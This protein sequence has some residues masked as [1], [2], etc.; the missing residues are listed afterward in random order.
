MS[1]SQ[2]TSVATILREHVTVEIESLDRLYLNV[3]MPHLQSAAG[4]A[5][6]FRRHR[7]ATFAAA[8]LMDAMTKAFITAIERFAARERVPVIT[9]PKGQRKEEVAAA[10]LAQFQGEEGLLFIGKAQE[11]AG[12]CRT[13]KRRNPQTGQTYPWLV[14]ATALVNHYYFYGV[15]RD[16]GPFFL[17]FCSYFPYNAKLCLN[18]HEYLKRQLTKEGIAFAAL[19]NGLLSCANPRR[20]QEIC[21]AL[22]APLIDGL[23][24]KWLARLPH[25]FT[26]EDRA[27]GYRYDV[28][29]LQAECALTQVLDRPLTGRLL[30]EQIIR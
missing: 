8:P 21:D 20:A 15:D 14:R 28:S 4:V 30:F 2:G 19:D 6:F 26:P 10:Y 18:G 1:V 22:T 7:G 16:F 11:K 5:H 17:K 12:V 9:F 29:I 13:E 27:A 23:L 24:R 3:Y 25:P